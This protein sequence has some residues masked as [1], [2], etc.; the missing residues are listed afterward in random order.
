MSLGPRYITQDQIVQWLVNKV[1]FSLVDTLPDPDV[2]TDN[3]DGTWSLSWNS[4][5]ADYNKLN[6][7]ANGSAVTQGDAY[8]DYLG[9]LSLPTY[10]I[11]LGNVQGS[12][13]TTGGVLGL[14]DD[15]NAISG[16]L[17]DSLIAQAES[18]V[19]VDFMSLYIV[20]FASVI[21]G[22]V[23]AYSD[24]P[25]TTLGFMTDLFL[26][27]TAILIMQLDFGKNDGVRGDT[28]IKAMEARYLSMKNM[29]FA[30]A[31]TG[32]LLNPPLPGLQQNAKNIRFDRVP[33]PR[34]AND[35]YSAVAF[36]KARI[37]NP[38][39]TPFL[40]GPWPPQPL[41]PG[42]GDGC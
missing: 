2:A 17:L 30:R 14:S 29:L 6:P 23:G 25:P 35:D 18:S 12:F 19:E 42:W 37:N 27:R 24:L 13:S 21:N 41:T 11:L 20:P 36:G 8:G 26:A 16:P 4:R 34:V 31:R 3:M 7:V 5:P 1:T 10:G 15:P 40:M 33:G 22:V 39:R 38:S 28:Y 32:N 9:T